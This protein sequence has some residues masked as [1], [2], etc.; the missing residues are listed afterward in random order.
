MPGRRSPLRRAK[1]DFGAL[2][3]AKLR[4]KNLAENAEQ[5]IPV[6]EKHGYPHYYDIE[7]TV[8]AKWASFSLS[9]K[10]IRLFLMYTLSSDIEALTEGE[11]QPTLI[12]TSKGDVKGVIT[13]KDSSKFILTVPGED[14]GLAS[15]WLRDLSD[16][17]IK[18]DED[19]SMRVPGPMRV[20]PTDL[21]EPVKVEG[22][23]IGVHKPY[24]IGMEADQRQ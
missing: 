23:P 5:F 24:Y 7:D 9:G 17:Y 6:K 2:E 13:Y 15:A 11:S 21:E 3:D 18:F 8:N 4:V 14:A 22:E 10:Q 16:A 19:L 1:V 12:H 20:E